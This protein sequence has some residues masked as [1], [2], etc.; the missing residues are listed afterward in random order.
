MGNASMETRRESSA[1]QLAKRY[2]VV[3]EF[4]DQ[5]TEPLSPE[6]CVIQSMPDVSPTRW[7]LARTRWSPSAAFNRTTAARLRARRA[8]SASTHTSSCV[9]PTGLRLLTPASSAISCSTVWLARTST[10][11]A[12]RNS[13]R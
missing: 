6:D 10:S 5:I 13:L 11:S 9:Y 8:A 1:A 7:H 12:M 4:S 3:R 2:Q